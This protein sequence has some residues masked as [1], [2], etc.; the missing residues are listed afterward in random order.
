MPHISIGVVSV[1]SGRG[2]D[3]DHRPQVFC[4]H[5]GFSNSAGSPPGCV[6]SRLFRQR[7]QAVSANLVSLRWRHLRG[8]SAHAL[9]IPKG[10]PLNVMLPALCLSVAQNDTISQNHA[11]DFVWNSCDVNSSL[12]SQDTVI[13]GFVN[14]AKLDRPL[15]T[16][17]FGAAP[18]WALC[19]AT[20][21]WV[22]THWPWEIWTKF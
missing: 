17:W 9:R 10:Y 7:R 3:S 6:F 18:C 16:S 4:I 1:A 5:H 19:A 12:M 22:L 8:R 13:G 14:N 21:Q 20:F 11:N 2:S 15:A